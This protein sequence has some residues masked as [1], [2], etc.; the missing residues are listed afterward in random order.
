[1]MNPTMN[2]FTSR[3]RSDSANSSHY[4]ASHHARSAPISNKSRD[5]HHLPSWSRR[6][7]R[8]NWPK[9]TLPELRH[10]VHVLIDEFMHAHQ[11]A[12]F[13]EVVLWYNSYSAVICSSHHH[14]S[15][16][17]GCHSTNIPDD[18]DEMV[19]KG[20]GSKID[21]KL[22]SSNRQ[23]KSRT[24]QQ[25]FV[26]KESGLNS[27]NAKVGSSDRTWGDILNDA[28]HLLP[29]MTPYE[30]GIVCRLA[31][32]CL[33]SYL[34]PH[35]TPFPTLDCSD[36]TSSSHYITRSARQTNNGVVS[37]RSNANH[38]SSRI[39][40]D[41]SCSTNELFHLR[42]LPLEE[43]LEH[44]LRFHD[45]SSIQYDPATIQHEKLIASL[46]HFLR[47][48]LRPF[49]ASRPLSHPPSSSLCPSSYGTSYPKNI[50]SSSSSS[51]SSTE[52]SDAG[53]G[54]GVADLLHVMAMVISPEIPKSLRGPPCVNHC[55][56]KEETLGNNTPITAA[57]NPHHHHQASR[58]RA[59]R[60]M[61]CIQPFYFQISSAYRAEMV[62]ILAENLVLPEMTKSGNHP[63]QSL[64]E[65][66]QQQHKYQDAGSDDDGYCG[67]GGNGRSTNQDHLSQS[68]FLD[69]GIVHL[70]AALKTFAQSALV[71]SQEM[72]ARRVLANI[73]IDCG[74]EEFIQEEMKALV[75][76]LCGSQDYGCAED[77]CGGEPSQRVTRCDRNTLQ[78]E[79]KIASTRE[80]E[81]QAHNQRFVVSSSQRIPDSTTKFSST[82][83]QQIGRQQEGNKD[84]VSIHCAKGNILRDLIIRYNGSRYYADEIFTRMTLLELSNALVSILKRIG[85]CCDNSKDTDMSNLQDEPPSVEGGEERSKTHE[86]LKLP[87]AC[88]VASLLDCTRALFY[89]LLNVRAPNNIPTEQEGDISLVGETEDITEE[90][91]LGGGEGRI[92]DEG[93]QLEDKMKDVVIECAI[94]LLVSPDTCVSSSASSLLSLALAYYKREQLLPH[95]SKVFQAI[96]FSISRAHI[97]KRQ[98]QDIVTVASRLSYSFA[99]SMLSLLIGLLEDMNVEK[100]YNTLTDRRE[101]MLYLISSIALAKPRAVAAQTDALKRIHVGWNF[102]DSTV[103]HII[104]IFLSCR[105]AYN[106]NDETGALQCYQHTTDLLSSVQDPWSMFQLGRHAFTSSNF[107]IA[108]TI[109]SQLQCLSSSS[110]SLLWF[111]ALSKIAQAEHLIMEEASLGIPTALPM[112]DSAINIIRSL[113]TFTSNKNFARGATASSPSLP[114]TSFQIDMLCRRKD[115]LN[116]CLIVRGICGEMRLTDTTAHRTTRPYVHQRNLS[117]CFHLLAAQYAKISKQ[118]GIIYCQQTRTALRGLFALSQ[119]L[120]IATRKVFCESLRKGSS[121]SPDKH[122]LQNDQIVWP[123][124][125]DCHPLFKA[126]KKM[127]KRIIDPMNESVEP[128]VRA[129]AML[130]IVSA[131]LRSPPLSARGFL[132]LKSLPLA[133]IRL[134]ENINSSLPLDTDNIEDRMVDGEADIIEAQTGV[135]CTLHASGFLPNEYFQKS[136]LLFSQVIVCHTVLYDGPLLGEE[137]G[138]DPQ[139]SNI[140]EEEKD[141]HSQNDESSITIASQLLP[142]GEYLD[143]NGRTLFGAKF[144]STFV[145]AP[146]R[147]EGYYKIEVKLGV[148]DVRF[149]E[150]EI[151]IEGDCGVIFLCVSS[152]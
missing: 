126:L 120:A 94:Q 130:Q 56:E 71:N 145:C 87:V 68:H 64:V 26:D 72:D 3:T 15:N 4:N 60:L 133:Q 36:G 48:G 98:F 6:S 54:V 38:D 106:F 129:E 46:W 34:A 117:K 75:A 90:T 143:R 140:Y 37:A 63:E 93:Q 39:N 12:L 142:G 74:E 59:Q 152:T 8:N 31:S 115:F 61:S 138:E 70:R 139:T 97:E 18:D 41:S 49:L 89:F 81:R 88:Q 141:E 20:G 127:K 99:N 116:L 105:S 123:S 85:E 65:Q 147:R 47:V 108:H 2:R 55:R 73:A 22:S 150:Y 82:F 67:D 45:M 124:G 134:Y 69:G 118:F 103:R 27:T 58:S 125:D 25:N 137:D 83:L 14:H 43:L 40:R 132:S 50:S 128:M 78:R 100:K 19:I 104:S 53:A 110:S 148:R 112:L 151:P 62:H 113:A 121:S 44:T 91:K 7:N 102:N 30:H 42:L 77:A 1:M 13:D 114:I 144:L 101:W 107:G 23:K 28:S 66:Q 5:P 135:P 122:L 16:K 32:I 84:E 96:K 149:G 24:N 51:P 86:T 9:M 52:S 29:Y 57:S 146:I 11:R 33:L 79:E 109:F 21:K 131:V 119:F 10:E 95:V 80:Q 35:A 111:S 17:E 136:D 92:F 76:S